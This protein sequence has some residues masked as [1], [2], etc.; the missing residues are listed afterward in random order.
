VQESALATPIAP[1]R[2]TEVVS[3]LNMF[4]YMNEYNMPLARMGFTKFKKERGV[5]KRM[6]CWSNKGMW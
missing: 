1:R 5:E 4:V 6:C 3:L 2:R